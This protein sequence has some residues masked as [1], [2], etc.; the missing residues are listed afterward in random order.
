MRVAILGNSG[1]GKTTLAAALGAAGGA[2]CL[3]LDTVAWEP[4]QSA[5]PREEELARADV[6]VF[7]RRNPNWVVEGCYATLIEAALEFTPKL[8]FLNPGLDAC[9]ANCRSRPWEPHKYASQ[10]EQ[11]ANLPFLLS[12]VADYYTRTGPLSLAAHAKCFRVYSGP[13][14][15][16]Q[17]LPNLRNLDPE[18]LAWAH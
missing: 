12:W 6:G 5:V 3:D 13:K 7:C 10:Q 15:E 1:S 11:D 4:S 8:V 2:P 17:S 14:C 9:L 18:L 16:L